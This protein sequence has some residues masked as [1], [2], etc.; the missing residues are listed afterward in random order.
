MTIANVVDLL[1][2]MPESHTILMASSGFLS[3]TLERELDEVTRHAVHAGIVIDSIDAK[4][5]YT[6]S[7]S[8]E[9]TSPAHPRSINNMQSIAN[10]SKEAP[11]DALAS[12]AYNT[13]GLFFHNRNDLDAGFQELGIRP[14]ISYLLAFIP[15]E[16]PN[17]KY[18]HLK[19]R[20]K[21]PSHNTVQARLG[22]MAVQPPRA[23]PR[24]ERRIDTLAVATSVV[25]EVPGNLTTQLVHSAS[26]ERGVMAVFH[27]DIQQ[28]RFTGKAG[29]RQQKII[30]IAML[31]DSGGNF[32]TAKEG[33]VTLA[34]T[35]P[36]FNRFA[37]DGMNFML[38]LPAPPG[39]YR[40]RAVMEEAIEGKASAETLPVEVQ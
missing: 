10:A 15:D 31:L 28:L 17:G 19:V 23:K 38:T 21:G 40:L 30:L 20:L 16:T 25:E 8:A 27:V 35:E 7:A 4:G 37:A 5:L 39:S 12:L 32:V 2:R 1:G 36:T 9:K 11:N 26:G 14:D 13:G 3:G 29:V 6:E 34:L 22:Y 24:P 18:R 33:T